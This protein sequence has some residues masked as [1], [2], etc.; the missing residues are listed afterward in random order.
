MSSSIVN[1]LIYYFVFGTWALIEDNSAIQAL[2][3]LF[4]ISYLWILH[5]S[6]KNSIKWSSMVL[7]FMF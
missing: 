3:R 1:L 7:N 4:D 5:Y 2:K 6:A